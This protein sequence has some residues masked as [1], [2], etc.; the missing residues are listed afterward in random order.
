MAEAWQIVTQQ[1][2]PDGPRDKWPPAAANFDDAGPQHAGFNRPTRYEGEVQNLEINGTIPKEIAGTFYRVMPEPAFVPFVKNDIWLNGDGV[3]SAFR[4]KDGHIDF[5]QKFVQ[6]EK[7]QREKEERRALLGKYRNKFTDLVTFQERTVAN[8]SVIPFKGKILA[9]KED[10]K[11]Y[12]MDPSSL[13]TLGIFDFDGQLEGETF[14]A[15]PKYDAKTRELLAFGYEAKGVGSKDIFYMSIDQH[16]KMTEKVWFEAPF[17]GFQHEMAITENYVIFPVAPMECT[18]ENLKAGGNHW[19]WTSERPYYIGV[20][21][22]RGA[23]AADVKWFYGINAYTAHVANAYEEDGQIKLFMTL[24]PGNAFGF[25]PDEKGESPPIGTVPSRLTEWTIDPKATD[26]KLK[27]PMPLIE[28]L[29]EFP[30]IDDR[31]MG[32]PSRYVYGN[33]MDFTPGKTDWES[34]VPKFG[35]GVPY[36]N[37]IFKYDHKT[38]KLEKYSNGPHRFF[39]EPQFIPRSPTAAEG[40]GYLVALVNNLEEMSS[41]LVII[42]CNDFTNHVALARLPV[43]LR[44]GFHGSWVDDGDIDGRPIPAAKELPVRD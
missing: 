41:E 39:Q 34:C 31:V 20:L 35:G 27:D 10:G 42:D 5:S 44:A 30:R 23:T 13:A 37:T 17:C 9:L 26:L 24:A 32:Y 21:P 12:A 43:R 3:V 36:L 33:L 16:G 11:P 29:D 40:D 2:V 6:T 18:L 4:I 8:T 28:E 7:L 22:R 15:H 25:F 1:L 19:V 14:T 38:G